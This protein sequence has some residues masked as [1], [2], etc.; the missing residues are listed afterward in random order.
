MIHPRAVEHDR[1]GEEQQCPLHACG[2]ARPDRTHP[3]H[4]R[5]VGSRHETHV[6]DTDD[7]RWYGHDEGE[8]EAVQQVALF[9]SVHVPRTFFK[10]G[11]VVYGRRERT[12]RR[13]AR[14]RDGVDDVANSEAWR[15]RHVGHRQNG[16]RVG[17]DGL[18]H[19]DRG[20]QLAQQSHNLLR[21]VSE[22]RHTDVSVSI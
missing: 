7:E 9:A 13:D 11:R 10:S 16:I 19:R 22:R 17:S 20:L 21:T 6:D 3:P 1:C 2:V 12:R 18:H 4:A 5:T 15:G 14:A 8:D